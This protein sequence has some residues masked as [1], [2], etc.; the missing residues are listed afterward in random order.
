MIDPGTSPR[1]SE[2]RD[3]ISDEEEPRSYVFVLSAIENKDKPEAAK[4]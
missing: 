3:V 4:R 2:S 1:K